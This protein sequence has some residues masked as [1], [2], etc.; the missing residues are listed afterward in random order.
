MFNLQR[1]DASKLARNYIIIL[2]YYINILHYNLMRPPSY[3]RS[4]VD[5]NVVLRRIPVL[6]AYV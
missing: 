6:K 4:V 1:K 3:M 2:L 5:R